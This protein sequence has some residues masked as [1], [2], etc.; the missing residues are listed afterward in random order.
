MLGPLHVLIGRRCLHE[1]DDE[2]VIDALP[3]EDALLGRTLQN[4]VCK[5]L[6]FL[7][8]TRMCAGISIAPS[9]HCLVR[10]KSLGREGRRGPLL[11]GT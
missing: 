4:C 8:S 10:V 5:L 11:Q 9:V 1:E 6:R 3:S 7:G 2:A